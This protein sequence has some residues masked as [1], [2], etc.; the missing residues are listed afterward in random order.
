MRSSTTVGDGP[1]CLYCFRF[2]AQS[3]AVTF[4]TRLDTGTMTL[5]LTSSIASL[6]NADQ[7]VQP[8]KEIAN[9]LKP[10]RIIQQS[11]W[12][13]HVTEHAI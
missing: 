1:V 4:C 5:E 6:S 3:A 2:D 10:L 12:H 13:T 11:E 8:G 9:A 7:R